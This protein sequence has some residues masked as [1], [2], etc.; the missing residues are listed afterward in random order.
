MEGGNGR[1]LLNIIYLYV[2]SP[3]LLIDA[4]HGV[5]LM[6]SVIIIMLITTC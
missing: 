5:Y 1:T 2:S 6:D 4:H 3:E